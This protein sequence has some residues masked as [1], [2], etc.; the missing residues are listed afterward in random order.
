[1]EANEV[2]SRRELRVNEGS[3]GVC[4]GK[5]HNTSLEPRIDWCT[6]YEKWNDGVTILRE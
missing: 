4:V 1:M 2:T 3:E 5:K 6:L